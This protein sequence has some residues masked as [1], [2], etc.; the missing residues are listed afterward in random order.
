MGALIYHIVV[1]S[2]FR[3]SVVADVYRPGD[4]SQIGFVHCAAEASVIPVADDYYAD[5]VGPVL[6]LEIDPDLLG[7]E[8][9]YEAA[10]PIDGGGTSH[11]DT[12]RE[13]PHV[14][15]PIETRAIA[16]VGVLG[17]GEGGFL[18]PTEFAGVASFL[19]SS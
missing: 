17:K 10:A 1:Q 15:G 19:S 6:L 9:R 16:R 2:D 7:S 13:F 12:A 5:A 3:K 14:Y 4:L 18:W 11:L 8:T